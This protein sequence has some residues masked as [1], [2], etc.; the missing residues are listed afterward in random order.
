M[1]ERWLRF[2][3]GNGSQA[4][5]DIRLERVTNFEADIPL[6]DAGRL[7]SL[8]GHMLDLPS[9]SAN[10]RALLLIRQHHLCGQYMAER[11]HGNVNLAS[12]LAFIAVI[13]CA[14]ATP[15][16]RLRNKRPSLIDHIGRTGAARSHAIAVTLFIPNFKHAL[17]E[18]ARPINGRHRASLPHR[19]Q[20]QQEIAVEQRQIVGERHALSSRCFTEAHLPDIAPVDDIGRSCD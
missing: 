2:L 6:A 20:E 4:S 16:R 17:E 8:T 15:A 10:L 9:Q 13:A 3:V 12:I 19:L 7:H 11:V 1:L 18:N 14:R 5:G